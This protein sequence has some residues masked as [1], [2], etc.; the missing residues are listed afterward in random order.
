MICL[1]FT[2]KKLLIG[3]RGK[4]TEFLRFSRKPYIDYGGSQMLEVFD[5]YFPNIVEAYLNYA[6]RNEL[7]QQEVPMLL[8][9]PSEMYES[10]SGRNL[11]ED[12]IERIDQTFEPSFHI[13]HNEALH[14][15][16]LRGL[17]LQEAIF[18]EACALVEAVDGFP[19]L[20]YMYHPDDGID[21]SQVIPIQRVGIPGSSQSLL[22]ALDSEFGKMGLHLHEG[23]R[24]E[25]LRQIK[26]QPPVNSFILEK[27]FGAS[28]MRLEVARS[29][30]VL[31]DPMAIFQQTFDEWLN[32]TKLEM[33]GVNR[34]FLVGDSLQKGILRDYLE[35]QLTLADRLDK[36]TDLRTK[37]V[38][39]LIVRG[40][41][42]HTSSRGN[43]RLSQRL[44]I[45]N[46]RGG[47][48][49]RLPKPRPKLVNSP[50]NGSSRKT[51]QSKEM[52]DD[53]YNQKASEEVTS[54]RVQSYLSEPDKQ[55]HDIPATD[56]ILLPINPEKNTLEEDP[57]LWRLGFFKAGSENQVRAPSKDVSAF[58]KYKVIKTYKEVDFSTFEVQDKTNRGKYVLKYIN[59]DE[60]ENEALRRDFY[61]LY[62]KEKTYYGFE[63]S[64]NECQEGLYYIRNY[65]KGKTFYYFMEKLNLFEKNS[66]VD[67]KS[68]ELKLLISVYEA[69]QN[70][71][72][73]HASLSAHNILILGGRKWNLQREYYVTFVDFSV[74][75]CSTE[76]M[77]EQ[78]HN[79]VDELLTPGIYPQLRKAL[80]F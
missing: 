80:Q 21:G 48:N 2:R 24:H 56:A 65:I 51:T 77:V 3:V 37:S 67:F 32:E 74:E 44:M 34:V 40:L 1:V 68:K 15:A 52:F 13:M 45:S 39:K 4:I 5:N 61:H 75:D 31:D 23:D 26:Q 59:K 72:T 35:D 53:K 42:T 20:I 9:F 33:L 79:M 60:L 16:C 38:W 50:A 58:R 30:L 62:E 17:N 54:E 55:V 69:I 19:S 8:S 41:L 18:D 36:S 12:I 10:S 28:H 64:V 73:P 70:L 63:E 25:L 76:V 47:Q 22:Q 14:I 7:Q 43:N 46:G 6:Q 66:F 49:T 29:S 11:M 27:T 57:W 78:F 71:R